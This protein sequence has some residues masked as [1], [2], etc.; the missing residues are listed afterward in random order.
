MV[1]NGKGSKHAE[2]YHCLPQS[3]LLDRRVIPAESDVL[4]EWSNDSAVG[5]R[6]LVDD[7]TPIGASVLGCPGGRPR[8]GG[9]DSDKGE[10]DVNS[11]VNAG[12]P[13]LS[14]SSR[15]SC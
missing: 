3:L 15:G 14:V 13:G 2:G 4:T 10:G 7:V 12:S 8:R 11:K 9:G 5:L 1:K 6:R